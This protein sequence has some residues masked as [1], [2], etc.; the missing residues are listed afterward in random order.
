MTATDVIYARVPKPLKDAAEDHAATRG[1]T[2]TAAV[3]EL[4]GLGI[5]AIQNARSVAALQTRVG[6]LEHE[7]ADAKAAHREEVFRRESAEQQYL[8]LGGAAKVWG[9]RAAQQVGQ[10]PNC[11][12]PIRGYDLLVSGT[13][14]G[15]K[16]TVSSMLV[17]TSKTSGLDRNELIAL[18]GGAAIVL[19]LLA[20]TKGKS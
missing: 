12:V 10:C 5:E 8:M 15:C 13:C 7:L 16:R 17:P 3:A 9:Q 6:E 2:L 11:Q 19:G 18:L 20:A 1:F 14:P 4:L